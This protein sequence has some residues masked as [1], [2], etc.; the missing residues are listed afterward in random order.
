MIGGREGT[1]ISNGVV[2]IKTA[3]RL[4][5]ETLGAWNTTLMIGTRARAGAEGTG[6]HHAE[7]EAAQL[8]IGTRGDEDTT[9]KVAVD[10]TIDI[11]ETGIETGIASAALT[12]TGTEIGI[13]IGKAQGTMMMTGTVRG[14]HH[15]LR[16]A[17]TGT[18]TGIGTG[19]EIV[20]AT[21]ADGEDKMI[22]ESGLVRTTD[23]V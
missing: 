20:I 7:I 8:V 9:M 6:R 14:I 22:G 10:G 12:A 5:T 23:F 2:V 11:I 13:G 3:I 17:D 1:E 21:L 16:Q 4:G 18:E 15:R 19:I